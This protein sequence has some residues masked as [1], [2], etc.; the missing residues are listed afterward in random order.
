[1]TCAKCGRE[2]PEEKFVADKR[3]KSG[4][5]SWCK[6]CWRERSKK[7]YELHKAKYKILASNYYELYKE[8]FRVRSKEYRESH[9]KE[10]R[11]YEEFRR[12]EIREY[13][14]ANKEYIRERDRKYYADNRDREI[15][16]SRKYKKDNPE[17]VVSGRKARIAIDK[18]LLFRLPCEVCGETENIEAHHHEGYCKP[19][20][21]IWLCHRHHQYIHSLGKKVA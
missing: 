19:L 15:A 13:K 9:K 10:L 14:L 11:E 12:E 20:E 18:G 3:N 16:K 1:M 2:L 6:E 8:E 21:V 17:K 4:Y 7:H 5:T